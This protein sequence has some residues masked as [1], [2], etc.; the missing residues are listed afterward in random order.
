MITLL[1]HFYSEHEIYEMSYFLNHLN[2]NLFI[3]NTMSEWDYFI[4][5]DEKWRKWG[6]EI[7]KVI[8]K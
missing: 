3:K 5:F 4:K 7:C 1:Y 6:F 2:D 8:T